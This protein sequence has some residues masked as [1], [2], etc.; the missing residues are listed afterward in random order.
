[1]LCLFKSE[2]HSFTHRLLYTQP[3]EIVSL[4]RRNFH[5]LFYSEYN[6]FLFFIEGTKWAVHQLILIS[7]FWLLYKKIFYK[8]NSRK[9]NSWPC[10]FLKDWELK[11]PP[12]AIRHQNHFFSTSKVCMWFFKT[13]NESITKISFWSG[14]QLSLIFLLVFPLPPAKI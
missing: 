11:L 9:R 2:T 4:E 3:T 8:P 6:I 1:M 13:A 14:E 7:L 5:L 10:L 12:I